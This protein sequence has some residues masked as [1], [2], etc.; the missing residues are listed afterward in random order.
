MLDDQLAVRGPIDSDLAAAAGALE[1]GTVA[2]V[3]MWENRRAAPLAAALR[4][5]GGRRAAPGH[6][7]V[8]AVLASLDAIEAT[9]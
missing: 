8:Q 9:V 6:I 2:G 4:R 3:P 7:P 1:P 5:S